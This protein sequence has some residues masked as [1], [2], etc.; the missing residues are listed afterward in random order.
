MEVLAL[1]EAARSS[2]PGLAA[3]ITSAMDVVHKALHVYRSG[4]VCFSFNGGKDSTVVLHIIRAVL[5]ERAQQ[6]AAAAA[7]V[8][9]SAGAPVAATAGAAAGPGSHGGDDFAAAGVQVVYF[10]SRANFPEVLDFMA[11]TAKRYGFSVARPGPFKEGLSALIAPT[12]AAAQGSSARVGVRA[13]LMGTRR[14]DPDGVYMAGPFTPTTLN[15][16]PCMRV[17]PALDWS[18][19]HVWAFLRGASL[20]YCALYDKGYTSLGS[21]EDSTPNP[22]LAVGASAATS[23]AA[24]TAGP[25]QGAEAGRSAMAIRT[26]V[27]ANEMPVAQVAVTDAATQTRC[28][29]SGQDAPAVAASAAS[30]ASAF[31]PAWCLEDETA[32]RLGRAARSG[33]ARAGS[34]PAKGAAASAGAITTPHPPG[35]TVAVALLGD[36]LLTGRVTDANG[37]FLCS[38]LTARGLR[39]TEVATVADE[40]PAIA[41]TVK[42][43]AAAND[44]VITCGGLGPTHDDVTLQGV[45]VAFSVRLAP[46]PTLQAVLAANAPALPST[47]AQGNAGVALVP[48]HPHAYLLWPDGRA[49]SSALAPGLLSDRPGGGGSDDGGAAIS[50]RAYPL[51]RVANVYVLPGVPSVVQAKWAAFQSLFGAEGAGANSDAGAPYTCRTLRV[52]ASEAAI[53]S[54][55]AAAAACHP[56]VKVGSY[57]QDDGGLA[58]AANSAAA[59][60]GADGAVVTVTVSAWGSNTLQRA[61]A[62]AADITARL[63]AMSVAVLPF[64]SSL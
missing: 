19:R 21:T 63:A 61:A 44:A 10:E 20:P 49:P 40:V 3:A 37:A 43:L 12:P 4:E 57:P 52:L 25:A 22:L 47:G 11:A 8:D 50:T 64:A 17:C 26:S 54:V 59:P 2:D 9:A 33:S 23:A 1:R 62:A 7:H 39:V 34:V 53:A 18:Y 13:V 38:A 24:G 55:L 15:W 45:A 41:A 14:T 58:A 5:V 27:E 32:E 36:E 35:S 29:A 48:D 16:P 28:D 51:L 31:L 42:R 6:S 60:G 46:S 30:A 56:G